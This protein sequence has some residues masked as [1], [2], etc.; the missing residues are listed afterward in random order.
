M[1][2]H[3]DRAAPIPPYRQI[4]DAIR[5]LIERGILNLGTRLP[6]SRDL[7]T[8][9]GV[10]RL[11]VHKAYQCLEADG[12]IATKVGSGTFVCA[13]ATRAPSPDVPS[14]S[15][16]DPALRVWGPLF[17]NPRLATRALPSMAYAK[18]CS[19]SFVYA[20]PPRPV[21]R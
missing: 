20:A 9:V 19:A 18:E 10:N 15:A 17:V 5:S 3:V 21:P 2:I 1:Y 11:T 13:K 8:E 4:E 16:D 14:D 12:L 6:S 7:A